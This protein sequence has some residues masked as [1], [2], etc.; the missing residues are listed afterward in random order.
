MSV[1]IIY[2]QFYSLLEGKIKII[3]NEDILKF[4]K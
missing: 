4:L 1:A 2:T 3:T